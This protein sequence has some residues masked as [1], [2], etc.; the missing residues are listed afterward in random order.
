[1]QLLL[2]M[3]QLLAFALHHARHGYSRPAAH[4]LGYVVGGDLL[5]Y[6]GVVA[7]RPLELVLYVLYVVLE[8]AQFAVAYLSHP[9]VVAFT[10]RALR[11][12]LQL[13]HL[14][15]VLLNA[16]HQFFLT[17]PFGTVSL[18]LVFQFGNVL[19]EL[20]YLG[21]VVL[22][23]DSLALNLEL[24]QPSGYLVELLRN[25]VALHAQFGSRLIHKVDSLVG[26]EAVGD[27]TLGEFHGSDASIVLY[28]HLMVVLVAFLQTTQY[29]YRAQLVGLVHHNGLETPFESLVLLEVLLILVESRR[30]Y[31]P[32]LAT[33]K[34]GLQNV[35][36]VHG[37][38]ASSGTH[39]RVYLVYEED[40]AP[41]A[42]GH[43]LDD[44][45]QTLLK[46]ALVFGSG[47]ECSHVE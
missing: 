6:H 1:M 8:H 21:L 10:L 42:V 46:L 7:L 27:V 9:F 16:V 41:L 44:T 26:K 13:L 15:L 39:K 19:V 12:I 38:F 23:F 25:R 47:D 29:A 5:A 18:L 45:L 30:A 36:G 4:H 35:G 20:F 28:T 32:Q 24:F 22:A 40:D 2:K 14:E 37:A 31:A 17:F 33:C 43:F 3:Q 11:L 34:C